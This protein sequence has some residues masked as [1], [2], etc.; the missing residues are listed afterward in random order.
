[1][2]TLHALILGLVE[3]ITEFLPVSSTAHLILTSQILGLEQSDYLKSFNVIIQLGAILAVLVLYWRNLLKWGVL[4]RLAFAFLPTGILGLVLYDTVKLVFFESISLI[5][6][7]LILGGLV[8]I[9]FE[10]SSKNSLG[11]ALPIEEIPYW[12]CFCIGIFQS[13]AMIPGVSRSGASIVGGMSM[14]LHKKTVVEF[15]FLLAIPTILAASILDLY[16]NAP[17]FTNQEHFSLGIGFIGSFVTALL[18]ITLLLKFLQ[19]NTF[20]HFGLYR[21]ALGLFL[22]LAWF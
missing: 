22:L 6:W 11:K 9:L 12:N 8:L 16:K 7:S 4:K 18:S 17:A 10:K 20:T 2:T 13:L 1:M 14:G 3:G 19:K 21:I 5:L 15:S